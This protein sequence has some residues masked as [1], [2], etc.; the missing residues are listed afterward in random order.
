MGSEGEHTFIS[1]N[2]EYANYR[3][4]FDSNLQ[5]G[6]KVCFG[7]IPYGNINK[8]FANTNP[9]SNYSQGLCTTT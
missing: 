3:I 7:M 5:N 2:N 8:A 1:T 9:V 6:S 4:T